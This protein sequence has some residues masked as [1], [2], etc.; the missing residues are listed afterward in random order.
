MNP[1]RPGDG[2]DLVRAVRAGDVDG[3][4]RL[5]DGG[6]DP[7]REDA[8]SGLTPLMFAAGRGDGETAGLLLAAGALVNALD[9]LAGAS[10]LHKAC[11]GG[12]FE[13]AKAL[14]KAGAL[15]DLQATTTGHTPLVE[16]IWFKSDDIVGYLLDRD[17]RI[18]PLTYYGFTLDD[19]IRYAE[20]VSHGQDDQRRLARIKSLV[21]ARRDRDITARE[22]TRLVK[23]V[24]K[25]DIDALRAGLRDGAPI[26]QRWPVVGSF[27]DGHTAL[28]VAAR[29][30][31]TEMVRE[32]VAAGA[33]V[34]A[35]EPVFGAV[36]LHKAT[37]NGHLDI[38]KLLAAAKGVHLDYQGPS[39]GY[40]PLADAL[41]HGFA[42]CAE[43]LVDAG[44]RTDIA[45]YDGKLPADLAA[46]KLGRDHPLTRRLQKGA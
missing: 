7:N 18:E 43:V 22:T 39:N 27:D 16:A 17:A 45:G 37:Y 10:A 41:W 15:I 46:E 44:A 42:D 19:H 8:A 5:L 11:Q 38:T 13:V 32:L 26:D 33:D 35:I 34:N 28:L 4:R 2:A 21:Q 20:Q 12:H 14:V 23:A 30:G 29:N 31:E 6:A 1:T 25:K 40:T 3:V 24:Q 9:R 36:P